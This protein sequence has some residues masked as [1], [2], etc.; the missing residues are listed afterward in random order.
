LGGI[1]LTLCGA[2]RRTPMKHAAIFVLVAMTSLPARAQRQPI[3]GTYENCKYGY[4]VTLPEGAEAYAEGDSGFMIVLPPRPMSERWPMPT[5]K[6]FVSA[7]R[8]V[9]GYQRWLTDAQ[10]AVDI[11]PV[12]DPMS[13]VKYATVRVFLH[14][15]PLMTSAW[16]IGS[17]EAGTGKLPPLYHDYAPDWTYAALRE[18]GGIVYSFRVTEFYSLREVPRDILHAVMAKFRLRPVGCGQ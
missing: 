8:D 17:P 5:S 16:P 11:V 7:N 2:V 18:D 12:K 3:T 4:S 10:R 13:S 9:A 15:L 6:I 1:G 14:D